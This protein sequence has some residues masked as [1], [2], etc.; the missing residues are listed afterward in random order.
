[1]GDYKLHPLAFRDRLG[2]ACGYFM[3]AKEKKNSTLKSADR[4][5][6]SYS[7]NTIALSESRCLLLR[8]SCAI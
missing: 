5:T 8:S 1:M 2:V 3:G 6:W 7:L 4:L